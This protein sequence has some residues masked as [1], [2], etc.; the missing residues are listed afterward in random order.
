L[1]DQ[2]ALKKILPILVTAQFFCTS[3]WFAGNSV[4]MNI[5]PEREFSTNLLSHITSAIQVGFIVGT[6][7]FS[8]MSIADR[9]SPSRVFFICSLLASFSNLA[10]QFQEISFN[11]LLALRFTTGFFLAGIYPVGMKIAS[12]HFSQGLGKSLGYLVGALV[13]GTAL[14]HLIKFTFYNF[15]WQS[16]VYTT[17]ALA[18]LGGWL[19]HSFIPDG[20]YRKKSDSLQLKASIRVFE[21]PTFRSVAIGYFGHMWE[22]YTFWALVPQILHAFNQFHNKEIFSVPLWS[23]I[24]IAIGAPACVVGAWL[25]KSMGE[26]KIAT[27]SLILSGACCLLTPL[28]LHSPSPVLFMLFLLLW[29]CVVIADSPLFSTL[30]AKY[31]PFESRG[32]ALTVVTCIGFSVTILSIQSIS[33]FSEW[34]HDPYLYCFLAI[35]PIIGVFALVK[36]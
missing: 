25:S 35:G 13:I 18:I 33:F 6:L 34:I 24:I 29:G 28:A 15:H 8:L 2:S 11:G 27:L 14:P 23:F 22:L 19:V 4:L 9:Y 3:V 12:D 5:L 32:T 7:V 26:K 17:S 16:V 21:E 36:K 30:I 31:A 1:L 10:L 20:P